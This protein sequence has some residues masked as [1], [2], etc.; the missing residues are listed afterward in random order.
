MTTKNTTTKTKSKKTAQSVFNHLVNIPMTLELN[1]VQEDAYFIGQVVGFPEIVSQGTSLKELDENILD[2][3]KI[4][5]ESYKEIPP[6]PKELQQIGK[7][8]REKKNLR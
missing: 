1:I 7:F 8:I 3:A 4:L 6:T 5:F 2:A